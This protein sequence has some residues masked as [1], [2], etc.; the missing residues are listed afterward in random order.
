MAVAASLHLLPAMA[1][2]QPAPA[3]RPGAPSAI[4]FKRDNAGMGAAP[5]AGAVGALLALLVASGA[6]VAWL[7]KGLKIGGRV[8]RPGLVTVLESRR[9]GP[10][11][12]L[13]VVEFG[14]Q[15]YLLS[16]SEA[17]VQ[18]VASVAAPQA[19]EGA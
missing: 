18:C 11:A 16:Q 10:K 5:S 19:Q 13:S 17:G 3:A 1:Q 2:T 15:R 4:P 7:R 9:L 6:G 8:G 14:G 12:L